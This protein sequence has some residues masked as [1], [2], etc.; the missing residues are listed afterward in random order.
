M[1]RI[2]DFVQLTIEGKPGRYRGSVDDEM[3]VEY[4]SG[5]LTSL[6][7]IFLFLVSPTRLPGSATQDFLASSRTPE[8]GR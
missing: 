1:T 5:R 3:Q 7:G 8:G 2:I 4:E 6:T